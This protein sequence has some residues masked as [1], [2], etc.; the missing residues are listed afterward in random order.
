MRILIFVSWCYTWVDV[1]CIWG[2]VLVLILA[3][4]SLSNWD[5]MDDEKLNG[6][7]GLFSR[8]ICAYSGDFSVSQQSNSVKSSIWWKQRKT[9]LIT[10]KCNN[11]SA[12]HRQ[13]VKSKKVLTKAA[14][15]RGPKRAEW[16]SWLYG[17]ME[18]D[19]DAIVQLEW[20]FSV[21]Y[22]ASGPWYH[23]QFNTSIIK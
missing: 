7:K 11:L 19:F 6:M 3:I 12:N 15:G 18:Q 16:V 4:S 1:I 20:S 14:P 2:V 9:I 13:G 22:D 5:E 10:D 8:A 21:V 17:E 23:F